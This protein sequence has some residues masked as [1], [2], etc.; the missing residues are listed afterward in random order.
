MNIRIFLFCAS[1]FLFFF[2]CKQ[3]TTSA[4]QSGSSDLYPLNV[5]NSWTYQTRHFDPTGIK[6]DDTTG[7]I[8]ITGTE[9]FQGHQAFKTLFGDTSTSVLFWHE[10]PNYYSLS[11]HSPD[12]PIQNFLR[13]PMNIGEVITLSDTTFLGTGRYKVTL[14][15]I[16]SGEFVTS[17][18]GQFSCLHYERTNYSGPPQYLSIDD[19]EEDYYAAGIGMILSRDSASI[20]VAPFLRSTFELV[21][22]HV[23]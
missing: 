18:A 20:G 15:F 6:I 9:I 4:P 7:I 22:Y 17:A 1:V 19:V 14:K 16:G 21:N 13:D 11:L 2:G 5:G 10:A 23:Q 3:T 8:Q 12:Q